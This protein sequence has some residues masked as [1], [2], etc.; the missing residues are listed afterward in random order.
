MNHFV[1]WRNGPRFSE[2]AVIKQFEYPMNIQKDK[3]MIRT[4]FSIFVLAIATEVCVGQFKTPSIDSSPMDISYFPP[5]FPQL[6]AQGKAV[7][8]GVIRILYSRPQKKGREIF[9]SL[10]P[11][12]KLWRAGANEATEITFFREVSIAGK[13]VPPGRYSFYIVP[14]EANWTVVLNSETDIWGEGPVKYDQQKDLLRLTVP[15][16]KLEAEVEAWSMFFQRNDD[17]ANLIMAWD[18]VKATLPIVFR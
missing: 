7:G 8:D 1:R 13:K 4:F 11:Y 17:G 6:K 9:G 2:L 18:K 12:G 3:Y 15:V 14:E 5:A 10:L 16:E